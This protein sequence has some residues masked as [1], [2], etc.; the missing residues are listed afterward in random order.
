MPAPRPTPFALVFAAIARERFPALR[1]GLEA[2]GSDPRD[3][4]SFLLVREVAELLREL[5][6]ETG[7]GVAVETL[8]AL[9]HFAY[10][11]WMDGERVQV[12]SEQALAG[13]L[14]RPT[15]RPPDP[16]TLQ[17]SGVRYVQLPALRVWATPV[18]GQPA[19][20]LDG[21]FALR[22]NDQLAML[23]VLGLSPAR[24]GL[25]AV[26]LT[27][28]CPGDLQRLDGS[29]LFSPTLAGGA[30]AGLASLAG[31]AELLELAWRAEAL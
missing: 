7:V 29:P 23:A 11:F 16:P 6:P 27:G 20:P 1:A 3:R 21:W 18:A 10:L 17:P 8:V 25:T 4:D 28:S 14:T 30:A 5:R 15:S 12:I 19:E 2:A 26:E 24:P 22:S 9:L 31:E 13:M